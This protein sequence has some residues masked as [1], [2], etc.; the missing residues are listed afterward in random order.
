MSTYFA[1]LGLTAATLLVLSSQP[2]WA[3]N[4]TFKVDPEAGNNTFSAVFDAALGER[5]MAVTSGIDCTV[6][7]DEGKRNGRAKCSV[8]L[9]AI[10]VDNDDTKTDHFQQ[11]ATNK[12]VAADKCAFELEVPTVALP[13]ALEEKTPVPFSADGTFTICGRKRDDGGA[14][15][16][17]GT[18]IALPASSSDDPRT[19]RIR[20]KIEHFDRER[21]GISPKNTAGWLA[22]VQQLAP[23]VATDGTIDV[24]IFA[25][26]TA[27]KQTKK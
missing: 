2:V 25:T 15:H 13:S 26:T 21:Y 10:K 5:I 14:E 9:T 4:A 24:N 20:A 27:D 17:T 12:K 23:V 8:P 18:V 22:R 6:T 11:W 7:V 1:H 3:E 16:L 19:L